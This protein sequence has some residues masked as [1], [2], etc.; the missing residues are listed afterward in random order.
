MH[1]PIMQPQF[2]PAAYQP[3]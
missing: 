2:M 3:L 1:A